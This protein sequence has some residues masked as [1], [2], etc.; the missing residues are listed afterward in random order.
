MVGVSEYD[1]LEETDLMLAILYEELTGNQENQRNAVL[2]IMEWINFSNFES[3][4]TTDRILASFGD[5]HTAHIIIPVAYYTCKSISEAFDR[6][7]CIT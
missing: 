4:W 1:Y 6:Y 5:W 2:Y 3:D 7:N